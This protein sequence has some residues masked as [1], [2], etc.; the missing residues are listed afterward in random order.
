MVDICDSAVIRLQSRIKNFCAKP[1]VKRTIKN[2]E[3]VLQQK[4]EIQ[5]EQTSKELLETLK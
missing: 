4:I 5:K 2:L 3:K 1:F